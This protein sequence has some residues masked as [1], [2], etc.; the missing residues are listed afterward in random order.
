MTIREQRQRHSI[1]SNYDIINLWLRTP[2]KT[3]K[4]SDW[5]VPMSL[6]LFKNGNALS[7]SM[8]FDKIVEDMGM[9]IAK[10]ITGLSFVRLDEDM[11]SLEVVYQGNYIYTKGLKDD[12]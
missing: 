5:G 9:E 11:Y 6:Y 7:L 2:T 4:F 1:V 12:Y 8:I 10:D 3:L